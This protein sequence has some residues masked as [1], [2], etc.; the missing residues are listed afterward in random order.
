[1]RTVA[2]RW[3]GT[4]PRGLSGEHTLTFQ[5]S[6]DR[7]IVLDIAAASELPCT[8]S[9]ASLVWGFKETFRA[10][11]DGSIANGEWT[12][13]GDVSYETPL[14]TW[15]GGTGGADL[16]EGALDVQY[17]GSVRFTGHGGALDTTI[18][19]PRVVV[20]GDRA[21]L[22]L[23]VTG[24]TQAGDAVQAT[25]VEFAEL[26]LSAV[27]TARDGDTVTWADVPATLTAAGAGPSA[28]TPRARR[29]TR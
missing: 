16:E 26:D 23:D 11:I 29:S 19:N 22:L 28:P 12:T 27:E 3:T 24:T 6:V 2:S 14:F 8:V 7:G 4:L 15:A 5:G 18:A 9:D 10:Y 21:V 17:S 25:A 20:D 1:M 13:D